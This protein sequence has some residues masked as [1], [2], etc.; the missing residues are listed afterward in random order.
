MP[1]DKRSNVA[2]IHHTPGHQQYKLFLQQAQLEDDVNDK[3]PVT[4]ESV[5]TN[6]VSDSESD[7]E[8]SESSNHPDDKDWNTGWDLEN[9]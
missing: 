1:L 7:D 8:Q 2:N 3:D 5:S 4:L 9:N 6:M